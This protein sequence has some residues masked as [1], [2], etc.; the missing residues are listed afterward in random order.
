MN[1]TMHGNHSAE[2]VLCDGKP[3]IS[4]SVPSQSPINVELSKFLIA[5]SIK[6]C[7]NNLVAYDFR[8]LEAHFT[9]IT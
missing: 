4:S 8:R 2:P 5:M 6:Y 9:V 1:L 3:P 7:I